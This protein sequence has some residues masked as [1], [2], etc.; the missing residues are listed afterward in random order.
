M[1][2]VIIIH[3][4]T[5]KHDFQTVLITS[6]C[7]SKV[8]RTS[9][10]FMRKK[11]PS[12]KATDAA[13]LGIRIFPNIRS[14]SLYHYYFLDQVLALVG[15]NY[16]RTIT[17]NETACVRKVPHLHQK[18]EWNHKYLKKFVQLKPVRSVSKFWHCKLDPPNCK[19]RAKYWFTR[20]HAAHIHSRC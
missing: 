19:S 17:D 9:G 1:L 13:S 15:F 11:T 4:L 20:M 8:G 5:D 18:W 2:S 7:E 16:F 14:C 12:I 10:S 6:D 3:R